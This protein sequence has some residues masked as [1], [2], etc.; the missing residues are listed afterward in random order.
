[1]ERWRD[2]WMAGPHSCHLEHLASRNPLGRTEQNVCQRPITSR[3]TAESLSNAKALLVLISTTGL[4]LEAGSLWVASSNRLREE[5]LLT[6][7]IRMQQQHL[8]FLL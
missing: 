8:Q 3:I 4:T 1:M 5:I 7:Q 6:A 2:G